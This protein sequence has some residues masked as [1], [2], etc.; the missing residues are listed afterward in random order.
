MKPSEEPQAELTIQEVSH[1]LGLPKSTIRYWEK[2]FAGMITP[3]RTAGG[4]RRYTNQDLEQLSEIKFLKAAGL[5]LRQIRVRIHDKDNPAVRGKEP[6]DIDR[7]A[8][9]VEGA[10][11]REI[12][13]YFSQL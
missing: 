5:S 11:R 10:V 6:I 12:R 3:L 2:E 8:E 7:L 1:Q 13:Q 4:Q 9:R